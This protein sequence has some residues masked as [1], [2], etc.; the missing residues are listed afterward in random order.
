MESHIQQ[1]AWIIATNKVLSKFN[2]DQLVFDPF[3]ATITAGRAGELFSA[4]RSLGLINGRK[5]D[6]Y[7]KLYKLKP[8]VTIQVLK[9]AEAMPANDSWH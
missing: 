1:G 6:V 3:D 2:L 9:I 8:S 7:R 4:I 5:F